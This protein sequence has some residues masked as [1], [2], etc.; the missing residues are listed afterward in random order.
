MIQDL[1]NRLEFCKPSGKDQWM[2]RCPAHADKGPSLSVKDA[3][4]GR[5]LIHCFAGCGATEVLDALGLDYG[6][7]Y[8][9][10]DQNYHAERKERQRTHDELVIAIAE[11]DMAKG[12]KLNN[13]DL[14]R[15]RLA[16]MRVELGMAV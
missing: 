5:T 7:L 13:D 6:A 10:E 11:S 2:A 16:L 1:L 15:Y 14:D 12:V 9:P 4:G 8:P 3:G